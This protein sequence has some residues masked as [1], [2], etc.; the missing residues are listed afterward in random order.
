MI[1]LINP[2]LVARK[3]DLF[4]TGIVYMPIGLAYFA[5]SL[6]DSG[7]EFKVIDAFG[8]KPEEVKTQG[9]FLILGLAEDEVIKLIPK[10]AEV[11]FIYA[12]CVSYH[13][14]LVNIAKA[15]KRKFPGVP[16]AAIENTQAVTSYSLCEAQ[17][18][19]YQNGV[20]FIL[21]GEP[22][23]R[24]ISLI[25]ALRDKLDLSL[26][27]GLGFKFNGKAGYVK[28]IKEIEQ[29]DGLAFPA[30]D[31][32][33]IENYWR[34][35][36]GHG[37]IETGRYLP[38]LT[39]RG[40][41][42]ACQFCLMPYFDAQGWR[43]RSAKNVVDEMEY[44]QRNLGVSE[45]HIEDVNPAIS[46]ARIREICSEINKRRLKL[47]WKLVSGTKVESLKDEGTL[48]L[49]ASSG[50]NYI[51]ISPETG[52]EKILKLMHKPF[53]LAHALSLVKSMHRLKIFSQ[54][55]FVLGFPGETKADIKLTEK[56]I[57]KLTA[58]GIDEIAVFIITPV[59]GS[60]LFKE[61]K[62]NF[63]FSELN[64]S[65]T[66]REDYQFLNRERLRL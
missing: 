45:F 2:N 33:P 4:T 44:W 12:S 29:L 16:L 53:D 24:G 14:A 27:D 36:Y 43:G 58:V 41:P 13:L 60:G 38:L 48:E 23:R 49:M 62:G 61:F 46:D 28:P 31:A 63:H 30:W 25:R 57:K 59:P 65:P 39:S 54:A 18:E 66:W 9:S 7:Y 40:C 5:A 64:F 11:I 56:L 8:E 6:R 34:L 21:T 52:S 1:V 42:Y 50:C 3:D 15:I 37:P 20:D 22:E 51:S 26:I 10:D 19:L 35:N 47:I 32:F 55:C 17:E